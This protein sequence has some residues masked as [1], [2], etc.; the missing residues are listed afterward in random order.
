MKQKQYSPLA[1]EE[2]VPVIYAGVNGFLDDIEISRIGEFE[3]SFMSSL[4]ANQPEIIDA[5]RNKGELSKEEL[6]SLKAATESF[7]ASF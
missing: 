1:A 6:E 3:E 2:Q 7:V 4:K 5:I